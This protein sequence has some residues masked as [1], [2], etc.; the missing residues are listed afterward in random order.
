MRRIRHAAM[1]LGAATFLLGLA[2]L[3]AGADVSSA[4]MAIAAV[5]ACLIGVR[6]AVTS[7]QREIVF[8][9]LLG[10]S[11]LLAIGAATCYA[12]GTSLLLTAAVVALGSGGWVLTY[13]AG[14]RKRL[15][16]RRRFSYHKG[17]S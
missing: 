8:L 12:E 14:Q 9:G 3:R 7:L 6:D 13:L 2:M 1:V 5:V 16:R 17:Y 11:G 15:R 10:Y 4:L